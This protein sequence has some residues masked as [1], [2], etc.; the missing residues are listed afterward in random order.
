[1][2]TH[3]IEK[4]KSLGASLAGIANI[5]LLRNA[6]SYQVYGG[7]EFPARAKS[8]LVLA[9]AHCENEPELDWWGVKGG[10]IGN[11]RLQQ[12]AEKLK[13]W[14]NKEYNIFVQ[15]LPYQ[16]EG[17]GIFL[18]DAAVLAGLGI[19]GANNLLV[20]PELGPRVRLRASF[21]DVEVGSPEK[22]VFS[23]CNACNMPCR[24]NCPKN[25]FSSSSYNRELCAEQMKE[26]E[27]SR[28]IIEHTS[29]NNSPEVRIKYC[30]ACELAC[31][32]GR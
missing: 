29:Q 17:G 21:L 22:R 10:T 31:P 15:P 4:A 14:L 20:T 25:A 7:V 26:D 27:A 2:I 30:R 8:V 19:I 24:R 5:D 16:V 6:P 12:I 3:I 28:V 13:Q 9:L 1:M 32:I 11:Q 23:P 18:K